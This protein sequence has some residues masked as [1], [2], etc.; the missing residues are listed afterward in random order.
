MIS[1]RDF[2]RISGTAATVILAART[3]V[4][5][6]AAPARAKL[7]LKER[8]AP[9]AP[10][11]RPAAERMLSQG[12]PPIT[13]EAL[14]KMPPGAGAPQI[15]LLPDVPVAEREVPAS[16]SL[17]AVKV[18]VVNADPA[19]RRPAILHVHGGGFVLGTA[20]SELRYLQETA[21]DLDCVIV[22]VEYRLA[23]RTRYSGSTEDTYAG[24]KWLHSHAD[25]LGVDRSRLAV[26][27]ESAG[28]GHAAI[29]AIRARDRGE[30]PLVLEVLVYPMLDDRTGS[31]APIP[32]YIATVGWSPSENRLGWES[33]LGVA[34]GGPNV[35]V[36]AVPAR[37]AS[38]TGL[39]PAWVGVGGIDLFAAEDM[40]YARRLTLANVPTE[41]LVIPG[42]FH[43]FD[44]VAADTTLAKLFTKSKLN[45]LRRAFGRPIVI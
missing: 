42:A 15:P 3:G 33:F 24:L 5:A 39:A 25:E 12:M 36:A 30:I 26:M 38:L 4:L 44:R 21:R 43:G 8:L 34:P 37:T 40:A 32:P 27:G 35:P 22:T 23:P 31:V 28:G 2:G 29:L 19:Q 18:F 20:K 10:E 9:V 17:P 11:L 7:S 41:L 14:R 16:G 45:A 1:R 6:A 13:A